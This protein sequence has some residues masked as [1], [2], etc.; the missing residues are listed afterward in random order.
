MRSVV[1]GANG[2]P[3][4]TRFA[5]R[6]PIF[7]G[8][9]IRLVLTPGSDEEVCAPA[10]VLES[11][12]RQTASVEQAGRVG[13]SP[14]EALRQGSPERTLRSS[15]PLRSHDGSNGEELPECRIDARRIGKCLREIRVE[16]AR[17]TAPDVRV[18]TRFRPVDDLRHLPEGR[19]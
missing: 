10:V 18:P 19:R 6:D 8:P 17:S 16:D 12:G 11:A 7:F 15:T 4:P 2:Q 9:R 5:Q 3:D 1:A 13:R 14:W